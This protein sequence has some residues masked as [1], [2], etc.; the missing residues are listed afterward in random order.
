MAGKGH[1]MIRFTKTGEAGFSILELLVV[2]AIIA[3]LTGLAVPY[4]AD[5]V[6][7]SKHS[8]MRANLHAFE[9]ALMDFHTDKGYYPAAADIGAL[10]TGNPRYLLEFPVDPVDGA[11]ASW[12][13]SLPYAFP[14][15]V[16]SGQQYRYELDSRYDPYR[17]P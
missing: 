7:Q 16:P 9:K 10:V 11:P 2:I 1:L 5:Y 8:I 4:Y 6:E 17:K 13:Y 3:A 15:D 14:K 12:G